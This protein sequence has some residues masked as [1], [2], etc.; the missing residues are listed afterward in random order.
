[1]LLKSC[2]TVN[3]DI[4]QSNVNEATLLI[5]AKNCLTKRC[6]FLNKTIL[7]KSNL[8][9]VKADESTVLD[10]LREL[11]IWLPIR[12]SCMVEAILDSDTNT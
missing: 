12:M 7:I 5:L 3:A 9:P 4:F 1:M 10:K 2:Y 8:I 6:S 11:L